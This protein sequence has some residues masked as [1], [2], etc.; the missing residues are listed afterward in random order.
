MSIFTQFTEAQVQ[1]WDW[2]RAAVDQ[3]YTASAG[4]QAFREAGGHIRTQDWYRVYNTIESYTETWNTVNTFTANETIP[5]RFWMSAPR[6]FAQPYV[7]EV[8]LAIRNV[9]TGE[10][11]RTFRYIE[12]D[13]RMSQDEITGYIDEL[14][15]DYPQS[16]Q[17]QTE[18]IYGYKFY[19]KGS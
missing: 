4:L 16:E 15:S 12:S 7:A 8:E 5:E 19:K 10:L 18:Y 13:Y 11:Q 9:E 2:L 3:E 6:N 14:G 17:W 1:A